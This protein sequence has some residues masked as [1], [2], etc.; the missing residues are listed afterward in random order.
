VRDEMYAHTVKDDDFGIEE[1]NRAFV[2][3]NSWYV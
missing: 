3:S 2:S 1:C